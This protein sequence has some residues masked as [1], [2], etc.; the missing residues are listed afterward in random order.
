MRTRTHG[1]TG[2]LGSHGSR[3]VR[4]VNVP[5]VSATK[6]RFF[7]NKIP[8]CLQYNGLKTGRGSTLN[9]RNGRKTKKTIFTHLG[10]LQKKVYEWIVRFQY[11]IIDFILQPADRLFPELQNSTTS[12]NCTGACCQCRQVV[13][14]KSASMLAVKSRSTDSI[15]RTNRRFMSQRR[16]ASESRFF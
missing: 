11:S 9:N 5:K 4:D 7:D 12:N 15:L 14:S 16:T 8:L 13:K 10:Q 1:S 2:N 3:V 6:W